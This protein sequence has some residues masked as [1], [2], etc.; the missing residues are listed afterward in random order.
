MYTICTNVLKNLAQ[1]FHEVFERIVC[2][3]YTY[4]NNSVPC[5]LA[6]YEK[7]SS[8]QYTCLKTKHS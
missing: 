5:T 4:F 7:I 6:V 2:T 1:P 8:V 3:L